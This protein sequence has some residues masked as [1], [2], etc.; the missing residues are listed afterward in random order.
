MSNDKAQMSNQIQSSNVK[1]FPCLPQ[2]GI[3]SFDIH[4]KFGF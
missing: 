2:A 1:N 4:L 3:L